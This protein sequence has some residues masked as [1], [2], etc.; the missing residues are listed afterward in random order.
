MS[1]AAEHAA[2]EAAIAE[3]LEAYSNKAGA[4][5]KADDKWLDWLPYAAAA[6]A[7]LAPAAADATIIYSGPQNVT[8][9]ANGTFNVNLSGNY[10]AK[11]SN[12]AGPGS[13]R[14]AR[15]L[16]QVPAVSSS[17]RTALRLSLGAPIGGSRHFFGSGLLR[18]GQTGATRVIAQFYPPN[19]RGFLGIHTANGDYGWIDVQVVSNGANSSS[20]YT[21]TIYG[22]AYDNSGA[23]IL[24]GATASAVP[25]PTTLSL[26]GLGALALGARGLRNLKSR[27]KQSAATAGDTT[28]L[29]SVGCA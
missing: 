18:Q 21:T 6:V 29:L 27:R 10:F 2:R 22:W 8:I 19:S 13:V 20:G 24:A 17:A 16:G 26:F 4:A 1:R 12:G 7:A 25:E 11:L 23:S 3:K 28:V 9:G 5:V 14:F 15:A